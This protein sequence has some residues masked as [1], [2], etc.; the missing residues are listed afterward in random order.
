MTAGRLRRGLSIAPFDVLAS[1][2]A[3]GELAAAAERAGWDGMF[4]WD[5]LVFSHGVRELADPWIC[6]AAIAQRTETLV[7]GPMVTP[8]PRR[9]PQIVARQA[10]TLDQLSGGRL[11][12]GFGLGDDE[13]N[14]ELS[15]FGEELDPRRRGAML[16]EGLTA[17]TGLLS[18]RA[19]AHRGE[20]YLVDDVRFLP[21][22]VRPSGIPIWLAA[23]WPNRRPLRRAARYDGV[24]PVNLSDPAELGELVDEVRTLRAAATTDADAAADADLADADAD[25][26]EFVVD[27]PVGKD[28]APWAAVGATWFLTRFGPFEL[29]LTDPRSLNR[30]HA[31]V[32]R[33]PDAVVSG[34]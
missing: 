14:G 26:Y 28:P 8:L 33:G 9:R 20:H 32:E 18:G 19:F 15:R 34:R 5:H 7:L 1:P 21:G 6:L 16:T 24:F 17:L 4:V 12:L 22:P 11:I 10:L 23:Q 29:D 27:F 2:R 3:L 31:I 13:R 25:G 30:I